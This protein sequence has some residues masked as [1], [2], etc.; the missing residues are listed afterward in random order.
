MASKAPISPLARRPLA[1]ASIVVTRPAATAAALRRRIVALGGT[2]V[3]LPGF[4][5]GRVA[6]V[7]AAR[8]ALRA[9]ASADVV[10][11]TSPAAVRHAW[12]LLPTLRLRRRTC[13][14]AP[15]AGSVRAL[16]RRGVAAVFPPDRQDSE[17]LLRMP[18]LARVRGRRVT[19][20]GAA[21]GRDLLARELRARGARVT[22]VETYRRLPP[23]LTRRH[24]A[25]LEAAPPP[26]I[27]L[28]SSADALTNL[29]ARLPP[30]LFARL[31]TNDCVASSERIAAA[32]RALGFRRVHRAASAAP[33][34]LLDEARTVLALHRL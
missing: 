1:G 17:G 29:C 2:P 6:D 33:E 34:A 30:A 9:T 22:F 19:L 14:A 32:A 25:V 31:A 27:V 13:V 16:R 21:G 3:G 18:P 12:Q 24:L 23:R 10:V 20:V 28:A 7:A 15:G 11:F 4:G 5:L 26:L 8:R